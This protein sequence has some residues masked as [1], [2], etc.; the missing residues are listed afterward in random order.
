MATP[1]PEL[2]VPEPMRRKTV[3]V[4]EACKAVGVTR[5]TIYNW[6]AQGKIEYT[7]TAGGSKRIYADSLWKRDDD[8]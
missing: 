3:T 1:A 8:E 2:A 7:E 5:R 6:M 4:E